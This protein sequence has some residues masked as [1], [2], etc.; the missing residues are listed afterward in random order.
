MPRSTDLG[1]YAWTSRTGGRLTRSETRKLLPPLAGAHLRNTVGR[2]GMAARLNSGRHATVDLGAITPPSS[3]VT[4]AAEEVARR[5]LPPVLL[6]HSFR[7]Y[8]FGAALGVLEQVD[9]DRELLFAAAMLH[10]LGLARPSENLDFTL[11]SARAARDVAEE[12]GLST[13]AT[14]TVRSAITRHHSPGVS[15]ADGAVAYLL[16]AGAGVDVIG[17]RSW[18]LPPAVLAAAVNAHPRMS[19]KREFAAAWRAEAAAVPTGRARLLRRYGAFD[20]AIRLAP[21]LD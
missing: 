16:S 4:R 1:S 5:E 8:V 18:K 14:E 7:T 6:N 2:L 21:F 17:Y 19:F 20:L 15:L 11:V 10:D 3:V 9:V 12:V 13:A